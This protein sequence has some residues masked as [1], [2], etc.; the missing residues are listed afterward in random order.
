M[1]SAVSS[2]HGYYEVGNEIFIN[3]TQAVYTASLTQQPV[4]WRF[5]E[6]TYSN[7]NWQQRPLGTLQELYK[8]RAQQLRDTYDHI[9]VYFSGGMDSW[10]VLNSFLSNG[11]HI[12]EVYTSWTLAETKYKD[13]DPTNTSEYNL[14]SE[15]EYAVVP[16]LNHLEKNYPN[17]NIVVNDISDKFV[18]DLKED[19]FF[20]S[21]VYQNITTFGR[22]NVESDRLRDAIAKNKK[23]GMV[24]GCDKI[25]YQNQNGIF[26]AF[27]L[28]VAVGA[29]V[30]PA[31][32]IEFFYQ[33]VDLPEIPVLQAH[34]I[35]DLITAKQ[36][37]LFYSG[38]DKVHRSK[39][40]GR[41]TF[42][43]LYQEACYPDYNPD[44]FQTGKQLGTLVRQSE[45]WIKDY[46]PKF[47]DSW[48]WTTDQY[49][50]SIN[51]QHLQKFNNLILGLNNLQSPL[52]LVNT[53]NTLPDFTYFSI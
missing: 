26:Y 8:I 50:N 5:H 47:Y 35:L 12:D 40:K 25:R 22:Q 9:V 48:K 46:N 52:Y 15:Y 13:F 1:L 43:Q 49:F 33:T 42:D 34:Y 21:N 18:G 2:P 19:V 17:I 51:D 31:K 45:V 38:V 3:K 14:I 10:N 53:N 28:D 6:D 7:I 27:F 32:Q 44:T 30:D 23:I 20:S 24:Y 37:E 41:K 29:D 36:Q 16:V 11:I 4:V 39:N